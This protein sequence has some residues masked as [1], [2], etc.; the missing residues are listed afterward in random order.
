MSDTF[1]ITTYWIHHDS[2]K[3][4]RCLNK[5]LRMKEKQYFRRFREFLKKMQ[6]PRVK[7]M[8]IEERQTEKYLSLVSEYS[9]LKFLENEPDLYTVSDLKERYK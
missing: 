2:T 4:R 5:E 1:R 6:I 7:D 8:V 3:D 9:L